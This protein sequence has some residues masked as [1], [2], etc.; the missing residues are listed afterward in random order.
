MN[1]NLLECAE[2]VLNFL[3][4]GEKEFEE[5]QSFD[6]PSSF[7]LAK[8]LRKYE[9]KKY[10]YIKCP[11]LLIDF[12]KELN[13]KLHILKEPMFTDDPK[14]FFSDKNKCVPFFKRS[15]SLLSRKEKLK[16]LRNI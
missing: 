2:A 1:D 4:N 6:T 5:I 3:I 11:N 14:E 16:K 10:E 7:R 12:T 13:N 9:R 15:I 8:E